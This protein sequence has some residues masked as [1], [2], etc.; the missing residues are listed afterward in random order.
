MAKIVL[1]GAGSHVFSQ[2]LITDVLSYHE[3]RDSTVTL[4]DIDKEPLELITAF[5]KKLVKQR[6]FST[7]IE[8]TTNRREALEGADYVVV[9]IRIGGRRMMQSDREISAKYGVEGSPDM[10]PGG[11]FYSSRYIPV[12]I[13]ICHD[14]EELCPNA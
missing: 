2:H 13:D 6:R 9:T 7:K 10:G 1:I 11:V 8:S 12:I 3:L 14:M 4:M 5:A